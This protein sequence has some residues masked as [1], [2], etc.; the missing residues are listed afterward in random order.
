MNRISRLKRGLDTLHE[1]RKALYARTNGLSQEELEFRPE[2]DTWSV[3][4]VIDH[5]IKAEAQFIGELRRKLLTFG[6]EPE[7]D[8]LISQLLRPF[9]FAGM[10]YR[11]SL[12]KLEAPGSI[13]PVHGFPHLYLVYKLA[14]V[15]EATFDVAE[16]LAHREEPVFIRDPRIGVT[17]SGEDWLYLTGLH[18][19]RHVG[20][21]ERAIEAIGEARR[22]GTFGRA[23][24]A[25]RARSAAPAPEELDEV[26]W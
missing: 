24:I 23:R 10:R 18:E 21:I 3:G 4:E 17:F 15:R 22:D 12:I 1:G 6:D 9:I 13:A 5:I 25:S 14:Q 8:N 19:M 16:R 11:T 2:P 26:V 7:E 20:Q